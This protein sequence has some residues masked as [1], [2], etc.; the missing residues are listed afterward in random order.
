MKTPVLLIMF[1]RS[2]TFEK[3]FEQ[4]KIAK[5]EKLYLYQDGP[6]QER[7][8]SDMAGIMKCREIASEINWDCQV[9]KQFMESNQGC[10]PGSYYAYKWFFSQE[11][12]GIILEDDAVPS[13]SFF[14][15]CEELLDKYEHDQRI[16]RICGA[17]IEG[18]SNTGNSY[19]FSRKGSTG[20]WATWSRVA[21]KWDESYSFL[22]NPGEIE[23]LRSKFENKDYFNSWLE[24]ARAHRDTGVPFYE[25]IFYENKII[26][27]MLDV[28]P[29][30]NLVT[31]IGLT[32][33]AVHNN[34][35]ANYLPKVLRDYF[36]AERYELFFPLK[37]PE[38]V[39]ENMHYTN[40]INRM[41]GWG[42]PGLRFLRRWETRFR[43]L[44]YG[45]KTERMELFHTMNKKLKRKI[46]NKE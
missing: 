41:M 10:D 2:S 35:N 40:S 14:R 25:T 24:G 22:D 27:N 38:T 5:P 15:Y 29:D 36:G 43:R 26:N 12:K 11:Q 33:D 17:N 19:F 1:T 23:L 8:D 34:R 16:Y 42:H 7:Y 21:E 32:T 18:Q 39:E 28:I 3:V 6:R 37:H 31:N 20:S 46:I 44:I 4:V 13:Q 45:D 30:R 9:K